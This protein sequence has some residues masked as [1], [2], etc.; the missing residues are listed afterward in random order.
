MLSQINNQHSIPLRVNCFLTQ[1]YSRFLFKQK[2]EDIRTH[3]KKK[4]KKARLVSV[5]LTTA[6]ADTLY[7][8]LTSPKKLKTICAWLGYMQ[9]QL[10]PHH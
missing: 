7:G 4:K 9:L 1:I 5:D 2:I 10:H 3:A 8:T 6:N